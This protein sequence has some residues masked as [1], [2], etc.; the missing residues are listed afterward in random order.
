MATEPNVKPAAPPPKAEP[1][2]SSGSSRAVGPGFAAAVGGVINQPVSYGHDVVPS[3]PSE[4]LTPD[5]I[6]NLAGDLGFGE[7]GYVELDEEGMPTGPAKRD[8][9]EPGKPVARVVG[10][11]TRRY[12]E[13]TTPA[14]APLTRNMNP[15]PDFS[16]DGMRARNPVPV[17]E[18]RKADERIAKIREA[19]KTKS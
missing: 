10:I 15:A 4:P 1:K 12:D 3:I 13:V 2:P 11:G 16:D 7:L 9:P 19:A 5:E 8:I 6:K 17:E 14:G 18:T